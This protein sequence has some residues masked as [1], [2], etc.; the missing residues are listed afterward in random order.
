M[1][2]LYSLFRVQYRDQ[3]AQ[4]VEYWILV[5]EAVGSRPGRSVNTQRLKIS[6]E[7]VLPFNDICKWFNFLVFSDNDDKQ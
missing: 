6:E 7:K 1:S 4:L 3:F 2:F 5:Q